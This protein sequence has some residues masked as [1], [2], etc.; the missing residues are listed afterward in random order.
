MEHLNGFITVFAPRYKRMVGNTCWTTITMSHKE[1][2]A[3]KNFVKMKLNAK[4]AVDIYNQLYGN[5]KH[6]LIFGKYK[7]GDESKYAIDNDWHLKIDIIVGNASQ[8]WSQIYALT[9]KAP[10]DGYTAGWI[11]S[12]ESILIDGKEFMRSIAPFA[13]KNGGSICV[14]SISSTDSTCLQYLVHTMEE[15]IDFIY[16]RDKVY[17]MMK[18]T[19]PREAELYYNS[20]ESLI[21]GMGGKNSTESQTNFFLSW[22][23]QQGRFVT[24]ESLKKNNVYETKI[25]DINYNADYIIG[26]LDLA[27][28]NDHT[29]LTVSEAYKSDYAIERY[30]MPKMEEGYSHYIK[31]I[32]IYNL[33]KQRM[34]SM[35]LARKVAKDCRK[36]KLDMI[37]VDST[38]NQTSLVE[39][40]YEAIKKEGI[41]TL[42]VPYNFSGA[43]NKLVMAGYAESVLFSGR[44]KIP[45]EEYKLAHKP[46]E[47]FLDE[48]VS[49]LKI[50]EDNKINI[51]Y[52]APRGKMDDTVMSFFLSLYC[53]QHVINLKHNN[54]LIEIGTNKIFPRLNKF[55]LL[56]D[57]PKNTQP[58]RD[59]YISGLF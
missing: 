38:A 13:S 2:S 40:I 4:K 11:F 8:E 12:D 43:T 28:V 25:G 35:D 36:Y 20:T 33:D 32:I 45:L 21:T 9:A 55:K 3:K 58:I 22:D 48:L 10:N 56:S 19:S 50:K 26:G 6:T 30:G 44:C 52:R 53:V 31:D 34:S 39:S 51:Q 42:V 59:S 47:I 23:L 16:D 41:N 27:T 54:K 5:Q 46:Y 18:A 7:V 17:R 24:R 14:T 49:L 37:M 1:D 29:V 57:S 15:S